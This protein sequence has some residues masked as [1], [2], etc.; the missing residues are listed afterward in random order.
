MKEKQCSTW[1]EGVSG[2]LVKL[3]DFDVRLKDFRVFHIS[4]SEQIRTFRCQKCTKLTAI[5]C[6]LTMSLIS[7]KK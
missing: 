3:L 4:L 7:V 1:E 6:L 2:I 5:I